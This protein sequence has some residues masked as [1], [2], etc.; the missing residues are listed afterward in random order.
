M[1]RVSDATFLSSPATIHYSPVV[2]SA[3]FSNPGHECRCLCLDTPDVRSSSA[4]RHPRTR[5]LR[6]ART[7]SLPTRQLRA[8][9]TFLV[10]GA[11]R[12]YC[13]ACAVTARS[14][15]RRRKRPGG[16]PLTPTLG[17][18]RWHKMSSLCIPVAPAWELAFFPRTQDMQ[19]PACP[20]EWRSSTGDVRTPALIHSTS[21]CMDVRYAQA[22]AVHA[23]EAWDVV[24]EETEASTECE[25]LI[26]DANPF[27]LRGRSVSRMDTS[28][29]LAKHH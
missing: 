29:C 21:L 27:S 7:I 2:A 16:S 5:P 25:V 4:I 9:P 20:E 6:G 17:P 3:S 8:A 18:G 10:S 24:E 1:V 22:L 26:R 12:G 19:H 23:L 13:C 15:P 28:I 11:A 14:D